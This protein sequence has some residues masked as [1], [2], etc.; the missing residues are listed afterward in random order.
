MKI[1]VFDT[2]T[3]GFINK[4]ETN[5]D[6]QP[7]VIQFAGIM[8]DLTN[9]KFIEE[10]RVNILI[11]PKTPIPYASS[12]VHHIYDID[13]KKAPFIEDVIDEILEYINEP[14]MII[15]HNIE[16]DQDM[17]KLE[18]KRQA[19]EYKYK[20]KQV[21]CT[22]KSTVNFCALEGNGKRFKYPKLGELHKK[23]FSEYFIGAHD[24]ITD[25]EATLRCFIELVNNNTIQVKEKKEEIMSLF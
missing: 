16:Y 13:I 19:L 11:N 1:F 25:V 24:A 18:L 21:F 23:L 22:M 5:L 12:E 20:P 15:G 9:G 17:I 7:K 4:K 14:D 6:L 10:K 3:T 2:E 8:G